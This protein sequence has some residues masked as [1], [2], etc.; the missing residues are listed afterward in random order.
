MSASSKTLITK[1][2]SQ[3]MALI[4]RTEKMTDAHKKELANAAASWKEMEAVFA[5]LKPAGS[6]NM[7][8][9]KECNAVSM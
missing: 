6:P 4:T 7:E 9:G 8:L 1:V 5:L 3:V 2:G